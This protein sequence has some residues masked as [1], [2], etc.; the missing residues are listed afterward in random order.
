MFRR[1]L[2][3]N[4]MPAQP[5]VLRA[6]HIR[7]FLAH[8]AK[9]AYSYSTV[10]GSFRALKCFFRYLHAEGYLPVSPVQGVARP[11]GFQ[12]I[13]QALSPAQV[14]SLLAVP[15]RRSKV[16]LRDHTLMVLILDTALRISEALGITLSDV[17]LS[18]GLI[19]V[20]GKGRK[21]RQVP[22]GRTARRRLVRWLQRRGDVPGQ[23]L[24]FC[25]RTGDRL[26][27][28]AFSKSV[29]RFGRVA[30][31]TGVRVSAHTLRHTCATMYLRQGGNPLYLQRLLG[32]STLAMTNRY[33]QSIGA[34]DLRAA[35]RACSPMDRL[36]P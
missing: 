9:A 4:A 6:D 1:F 30:R 17:D 13:V 33:L 25:T 23:D 32:H 22:L 3:A 15:N 29:R 35:H 16:G 18:Q 21:A 24:V 7:A 34:D 2:A 19:T 20:M 14:E 8:L 5:G 12:P 27:K 11:R 31:I 28:N 36:T 26:H 10:D